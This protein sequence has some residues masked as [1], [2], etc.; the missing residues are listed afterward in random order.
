MEKE[1]MFMINLTST[2]LRASQKY[3]FE[4]TNS[5]WERLKFE[6]RPQGAILNSQLASPFRI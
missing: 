2:I 3:V 5:E 4:I 1:N 6:C